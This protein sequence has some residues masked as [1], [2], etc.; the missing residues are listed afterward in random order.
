[1]SILMMHLRLF[2]DTYFYNHHHHI[3]I[4]IVIF[5]FIV[6]NMLILYVFLRV[7][8]NVCINELRFTLKI[9]RCGLNYR[10]EGIVMMTFLLITMC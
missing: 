5:L 2:Y 6:I 1:M 4:I 8:R 7:G 10:L 9:F 3:I